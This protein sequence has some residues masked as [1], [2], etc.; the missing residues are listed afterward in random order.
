[1]Q[2]MMTYGGTN[3][4][5]EILQPD[6]LL[7][8]S[9]R[10]LSKAVAIDKGANPDPLSNFVNSRLVPASVVEK[11]N[12]D[13]GPGPGPG[14]GPDPGP[15]P[16]PHEG[17]YA[18]T[19]YGDLPW[20]I[21]TLYYYPGE[22]IVPPS[23]SNRKWKNLRTGEWL[24]QGVTVA[25]QDDSYWGYLIEPVTT[26]LQYT[27][28][29]AQSSSNPSL[30]VDDN[31]L[32]VQFY[33]GGTTSEHMFKEYE[34]HPGYTVTVGYDWVHD[35]E[36]TDQPAVYIKYNTRSTQYNFTTVQWGGKSTFNVDQFYS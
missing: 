25:T 21:R 29:Y 6:P 36:D 22:V 26:R 18:I 35:E 23:T 3:G 14:P 4:A 33:A 5:N 12:P 27:V 13:P 2:K 11:Y 17:Q 9:N 28:E 7:T 34:Y 16:D 20:V 15:D 24:V 32:N 8:P 10:C 30:N 31:Y 19:F 1:M